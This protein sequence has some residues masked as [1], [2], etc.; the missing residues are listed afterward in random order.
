[1]TRIPTQA[2]PAWAGHPH[3][4]LAGPLV[5]GSIFTH[6]G[7][8]EGRHLQDADLIGASLDGK[9]RDTPFFKAVGAAYRKRGCERNGLGV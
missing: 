8:P 5:P 9:G 1:M 2:K 6:Y 7:R 4:S 3:E